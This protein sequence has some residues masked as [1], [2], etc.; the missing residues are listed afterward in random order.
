[1][2]LAINIENMNTVI[3]CV[4]D[5]RFVFVES[6]STSV[7][8]T[9]LEYAISF[10]NIFELHKLD[11]AEVEGAIISSV[12]PPVTSIV[13]GAV[14]RIFGKEALVIGP[15]VKTKLNIVTDNPAQLGSDMVAN[16]VAGIEKYEAPMIIV[17][18]GTATTLSVINEKK[19][20]VG[21]MIIPGLKVSAA[22]LSKETAQLPKV[23]LEKPKRV[24][25]TNTIDCMKSGLIYGTAAT[26]DGSINRIEKELGKKVATI[27]ATGE[28]IKHILPH[29]ER[30]MC[31]DE[32][33]LL[34]GLR[35]IYERNQKN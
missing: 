19:Q 32:T 5:S 6:L 29:C 10:K 11:I 28:N 25:G 35:L 17:N 13:K 23:S 14:N 4:R 24:I 27:V 1:M 34:E 8:R 26:I 30:K 18:M 7:T 2:I 12:V 31:L 33:L 9:E 3:G 22:S 15:G 21:G 20:Y 16:A